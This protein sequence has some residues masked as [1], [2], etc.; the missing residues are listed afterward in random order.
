MKELLEMRISR[1][2]GGKTIRYCI[3]NKWCGEFVDVIA[4]NNK[5]HATIG[6]LRHVI[7]LL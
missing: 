6:M 3:L 7:T 1:W 2:L 4:I 5:L